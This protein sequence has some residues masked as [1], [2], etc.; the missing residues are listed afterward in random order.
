LLFVRLAKFTNRASFN[1]CIHHPI[2]AVVLGS[3]IFDEKLTV[4]LAIG[5]LVTLLGVYLVK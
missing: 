3:I 1:L 4:Y 5:G 2:V